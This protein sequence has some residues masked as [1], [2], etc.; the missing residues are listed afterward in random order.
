M[1]EVLANRVEDLSGVEAT[2]YT[3]DFEI[4]LGDNGWRLPPVVLEGQYEQLENVMIND[5]HYAVS[6][7]WFSVDDEDDRFLYVPNGLPEDEQ[8][9]DYSPGSFAPGPSG[10]IIENPPPGVM[11]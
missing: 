8:A 10:P 11:W 1:F 6:P 2:V 9:P 4:A 5:Q 3:A 7:F